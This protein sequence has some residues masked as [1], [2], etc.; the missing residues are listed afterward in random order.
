MDHKRGAVGWKFMS[1]VN[2][3][4]APSVCAHPSLVIKKREMLLDRISFIINASDPLQ[5][6][7]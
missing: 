2:F 5:K 4:P 6:S 1:F 7:E 3:L